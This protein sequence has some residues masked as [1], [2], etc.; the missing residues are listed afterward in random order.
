MAK[1]PVGD[2]LRRSTVMASAGLLA[3]TMLGYP[4]LMAALARIAPRTVRADHT[5]RP[6]LTVL[7]PAHNESD[8]IA[9][10]LDSVLALAYPRD[11]LE[12]LVVDDGSEDRTRHIVE[13]YT[14]RGVALVPRWPRQGK[15]AA[16]NAGVEAAHGELILL[17]DASATFDTDAVLAAVAPLADPTVGVVSGQI[18]VRGGGDAVERPAGLYW[19]YQER[20]RAWESASGSTVGVTGNLFV[21]RRADFR[22][23]PEDTINDEFAVAMDIAGRGGRVLYEPEAVT[24]DEAS[25]SMADELVR[26]TRINAGRYQSLSRYCAAVVRRPALLFRLVSH[27]VLRVVTPVFMLTLAFCS[28]V[29]FLSRGNDDDGKLAIVERRVLEP[30]QFAVYGAAAVGA[31][32]ERSGRR[33]PRAVSIAYYFVGSNLAALAGLIGFASGRQSVLWRKRTP[34][35]GDP[36]GVPTGHPDRSTPMLPTKVLRRRA[37][38]PRF[39]R[40]SRRRN[41]VAASTVATIERDEAVVLVSLARRFGGVEN[42]ILTIARGIARTRPVLVVCLEDSPLHRAL[43]AAGLPAWTTARGR[44]DPR[45]V[46]DLRRLFRRE[47]P[48]IVDAHN[49]Q[50]QLWSLLATSLMNG[51]TLIAT[52]G[53][54][55]RQ[56]QKGRWR[57]RWYELVLK[58]LA[59]ARS[60]FIAVSDS[61]H[62]YLLGT[63]VSS[64]LISVVW[65]AVEVAD[66]ADVDPA[67]VRRDLELAEDEFVVI[68]VAR[69][70]RI[71]GHHVFLEALAHLGDDAARVRWLVVGDGP[72]QA[73]LERA[74]GGAGLSESVRWLGFREEVATLL[75]AS[76]SFV[77]PSL[78]EGLPLALLEA[79]GQRLP[80]L[81]TSVGAVPVVFEHGVTARLVPPDDPAALATQLRWLMAHPEERDELGRAAELAVAEHLDVHAMVDGTL[82]AYDRLRTVHQRRADALAVPSE[83]RT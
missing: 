74:A 69:L 40:R 55:Y 43:M 28:M 34:R 18:I 42:R 58:L 21:F 14:A 60:G 29:R 83:E 41:Q 57:A 8:V 1:H 48:A 6:T 76:D 68:T 33:M 70:T 62:A 30:G 63:G 50:S 66:T 77:L 17:T 15:M 52:V 27:K 11:R 49:V 4:A 19:R 37:R 38:D 73:V 67:A 80:I 78:S 82:A 31:M 20:L 3:Y 46:L 35:T 26:R 45:L 79:A 72:D 64:E 7:M 51:P 23:L 81:A 53:S 25:T 9:R 13:Q 16:V 32:L 5:R 2:R 61:V 24:Y 10:K 22:P 71:K 44:G 65:N 39:R 54:E 12:L 47:R 59:R 75:R 56:E 36:A